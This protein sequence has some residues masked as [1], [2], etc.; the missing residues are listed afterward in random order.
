MERDPEGPRKRQKRELYDWTKEKE[1]GI[2]TGCSGALDM[3]KITIAADGQTPVYNGTP[4]ELESNMKDVRGSVGAVSKWTS[5][6]G[7]DV[8]V[9]VKVVPPPLSEEKKAARAANL[10]AAFGSDTDTDTDTEASSY[11]AAADTPPPVS[12]TEE[13]SYTAAADTPPPVGGGSDVAHEGEDPA[14]LLTEVRE[15]IEMAEKLATCDLVRFKAFD[16]EVDGE[17]RI[18]TVMES[19]SSDAFAIASTWNGL[20]PEEKKYK[21]IAIKMADFLTRL[22]K[23]VQSG[24]ATLMDMKLENIGYCAAADGKIG[25]FRLIDVDSLNSNAL[26]A[27]YAAKDS[28]ED[29]LQTVYAFGV[30]MAQFLLHTKSYAAFNPERP[31]E[32]EEVLTELSY[33]HPVVL[34]K[35][36][37]ESAIIEALI[38][39]N[40]WITEEKRLEKAMFQRYYLENGEKVPYGKEL[41]YAE[42]VSAY[43]N[44]NWWFRDG[45]ETGANPLAPPDRTIVKKY[46]MWLMHSTWISKDGAMNQVRNL[47]QNAYDIFT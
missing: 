1:G 40:S 47:I 45:F 35:V 37:S 7:T 26:T 46:F 32:D 27:P 14:D 15:G 13:S 39:A 16:M 11:V 33:G 2:P 17:P 10:A 20:L 8:R 18:V 5:T 21:G 23:C 25:E 36:I 28:T 4:M 9:V 24:K 3:A 12:D 42:V 30:T 34:V 43:G 41:S 44:G 38:K 31:M 22:L 6:D 19:L 29:N